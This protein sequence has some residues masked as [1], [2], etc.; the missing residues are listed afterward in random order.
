MRLASEGLRMQ[1][2][3]RP[4]TGGR[5]M[6]YLR[7]KNWWEPRCNHDNIFTKTRRNV[8]WH[9]RTGAA[10]QVYGESPRSFPSY[11]FINLVTE[12]LAGTFWRYWKYVFWMNVRSEYFGFGVGADQFILFSGTRPIVIRCDIWG[13][14][15]AASPWVRLCGMS[16]LRVINC[17]LYLFKFAKCF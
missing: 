3:V 4:A 2:H 8:I 10:V 6:S 13:S 7:A 14:N 16:S 9:A 17:S 5:G 15:A 12:K 1:E 11:M